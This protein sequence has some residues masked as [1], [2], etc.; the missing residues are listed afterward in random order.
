MRTFGKLDQVCL[1]R[2]AYSFPSFCGIVFLTGIV[3]SELLCNIGNMFKNSAVQILNYQ[4][5]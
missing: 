3:A 1:R 2:V 5:P 4:I